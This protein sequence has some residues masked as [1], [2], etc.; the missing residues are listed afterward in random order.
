MCYYGD[1]DFSYDQDMTETK[2]DLE[3]RDTNFGDDSHAQWLRQITADQDEEA[4]EMKEYEIDVK[5]S[6]FDD[7]VRNMFITSAE[8]SYQEIRD[9]FTDEDISRIKNK[10]LLQLLAEWQN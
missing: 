1:D 5:A 3:S 4:R 6:N 9:Y 7:H 8:I 2:A 10:K